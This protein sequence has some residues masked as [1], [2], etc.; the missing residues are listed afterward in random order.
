MR[1]LVGMTAPRGF[2][3]TPDEGEDGDAG[4]DEESDAIGYNSGDRQPG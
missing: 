2:S 1:H 4:A 3:E